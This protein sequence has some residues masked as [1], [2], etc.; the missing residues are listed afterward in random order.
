[1]VPARLSGSFAPLED[2]KHW[3]KMRSVI[4]SS[5]FG[6][7]GFGRT[8]QSIHAVGTSHFKARNTFA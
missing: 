3:L 7:A 4:G 1:M 6:A 8:A 5:Q 2:D